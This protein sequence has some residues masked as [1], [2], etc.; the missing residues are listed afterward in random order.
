[1]KNRWV[2]ARHLALLVVLGAGVF[3]A[4]PSRA[5]ASF[6]VD[7]NAGGSPLSLTQA[8]FTCSQFGTL[9]TCSATG[10]SAGGLS[11]DLGFNVDTDPKIFATVSVLNNNAG[12]AQFT[13]LFTATGVGTSSNPTTTSGGVAGGAT[14]NGGD[15]TTTLGTVTGSA[16]YTALIDNV[17]YQTLYNFPFSFAQPIPFLSG[18]FPDL[19]FGPQPGAAIVNS[20]GVQLDFTITG[21]DSAS[22]SGTFELKPVPEPGTALLLGLG[23]VLMARRERRP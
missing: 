13:A 21:Q 10:L 5:V 4:A 17:T 7:I 8:D 16:F 1:M 15:A 23:L 11:F 12:T 9:S 14:D 19:S 3:A 6:T 22:M 2:V 20:V 18:N